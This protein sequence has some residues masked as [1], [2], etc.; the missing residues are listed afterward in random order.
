MARAFVIRTAAASAAL[1]LSL[2][3]ACR[4][5]AGEGGA[6]SNAS[7][8]IPSVSGP[9][10][11]RLVEQE[12]ATLLDVRTPEEYAVRHAEG[13]VNIPVGD[14]AGRLGEVARDNPVVVYCQSGSRSARAARMLRDS[15]HDVHDLGSLSAW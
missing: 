9:E 12:G 7:T 14:L 2:T 8:A 15:G 11:H 1:F 5:G 13:A 3:F 6:A 10:A 4:D